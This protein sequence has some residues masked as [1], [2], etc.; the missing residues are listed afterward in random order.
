MEALMYGGLQL[1]GIHKKVYSNR[2]VRIQ[3]QSSLHYAVHAKMNYRQGP[4]QLRGNVSE[5]E[6]MLRLP[7]NHLQYDI[8]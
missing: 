3:T 1:Q 6:C 4:N 7:Y 8:R 2:S 5:T